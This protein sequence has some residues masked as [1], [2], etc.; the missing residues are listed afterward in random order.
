M[1]I[2]ADDLLQSSLWVCSSGIACPRTQA[3]YTC[4]DMHEQGSLLCSRCRAGAHKVRGQCAECTPEAP[5]WV[6]LG[7]PV[8]LAGLSVH[9][10]RRAGTK[11]VL[12]LVLFA[13]QL[14]SILAQVTTLLT[15]ITLHNPTNSN[16][17]TNP[18]N[19][20]NPYSSGSPPLAPSTATSYQ[21][22]F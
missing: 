2:K 21:S 22:C 7:F 3:P 12:A 15:R 19:P 6:F 17:A 1:A 13:Y 20:T 10:W 4:P 16:H 5:Y 18:T 8:A 11:G 14:V 9:Y